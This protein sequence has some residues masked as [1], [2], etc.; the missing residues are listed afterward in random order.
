MEPWQ[1]VWIDAKAYATDVHSPINCTTCHAGKAVDDMQTAHEG[2]IASP[3]ANP[4]QACGKCHTDVTPADMGSLHSTLRGYDT[5]LYLRSEPQAHS[6][7]EQ[8]EQNHC[9][10]C[11]TTCGDCHISQPTSVG[12]GLLNGHVFVR[13]P[14]MSQ[15]CTGCHGSRVKNEYF[16]LNEGIPGDVH[17]RARMACSSCHTGDELHGIGAQADNR[18]SGAQAPS[19][20]SCHQDRIGVGSGI[21]QHEVHPVDLL[22]CQVCHSTSYTNCVNCHVAQTDEKVSFFKVES[23]SLDFL[24]GRNPLRN[25][26][27]PYR[28]VPVRHVPV[29]PN[30]FSFYGE[31]LLA[32]FDLS[33][34]WTY[35]TP[36]NIQRK[37]PQTESC[38]ACHENNQFFLTADKVA[39]GEQ[40]ANQNVIVESAPPLPKG[41]IAQATA[42]A[43]P[44][45]SG[46]DFWGGDSPPQ[47]TQSATQPA[48]PDA[49]DFWGGGSSTAQP[50]TQP[51]TPAAGDFWGD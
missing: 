14:P 50:A 48:T 31:N 42:T 11:H 10:G 15:T 19:C 26:Q 24:I 32:R 27:R 2:M 3:A 47:S 46:G 12:G 40:K 18:Y 5:A 9:N 49:S 1:R 25:A 17:F 22:S 35:A 36:H 29:D 41:Y 44:Q 6:V 51:A 8:V 20:E 38:A 39:N 21:E 30:S 45:S 7:V 28:Y 13:T 34:T 23:S 16:G 43:T 33:P 4:Q 37:T